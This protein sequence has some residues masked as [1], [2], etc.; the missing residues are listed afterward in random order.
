MSDWKLT[1]DFGPYHSSQTDDGGQPYAL[2]L[3]AVCT[4]WEHDCDA[5]LF[6]TGYPEGAKCSTLRHGVGYLWIW[7][8]VAAIIGA[9]YGHWL[10][11]QR[12]YLP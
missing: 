7:V 12:G 6:V 3:A 1:V 10:D 4:A 5:D 11:V 8:I 2:Q 9:T